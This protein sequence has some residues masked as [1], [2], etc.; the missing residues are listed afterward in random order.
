MV[1]KSM[2]IVRLTSR[3]ASVV[4][5]TKKLFEQEEKSWSMKLV[6]LNIIN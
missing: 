4:N 1:C 2:A 6:T 5:S 3:I